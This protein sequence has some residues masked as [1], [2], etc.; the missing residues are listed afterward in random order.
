MH[1]PFELSRQVG[2]VTEATFKGDPGDGR[3]GMDQ[4][5][6]GFMN[7]DLT[8]IIPGGDMEMPSKGSLKRA[9]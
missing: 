5:F 2:L 8:N 3:L 7:T 1:D 9:Y 4:L 6:A